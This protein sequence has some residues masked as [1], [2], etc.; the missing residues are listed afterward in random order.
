MFVIL[1]TNH[2]RELLHATGLGTRLENRLLE[3]E[4]D[5]F[6]T[7]ITVQEVTQGWMAELNRC[8]PGRDQVHAYTQFRNAILDFANITILAFDSEAAEVFHSLRTDL[9]RTGTMDLKIAA[10]AKSHEAL[11][12]SRNLADFSPI[13]GL[14]VENWLD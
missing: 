9:R 6:T 5:V 14:K 2:Y 1:D 4:A 10:I 11:L 7:I 3:E 8:K 13:P 12:L